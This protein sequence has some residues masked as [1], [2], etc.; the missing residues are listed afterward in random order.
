MNYKRLC[1][2]LRLSLVVHENETTRWDRLKNEI[3]N[4]IDELQAEREALR[5]AYR[6]LCILL[7]R[8][9]LKDENLKDNA[10]ETDESPD[11]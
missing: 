11:K 6:D 10:Q 5:D 1:D 3:S 7:E 9:T 2:T 4:A 8:E